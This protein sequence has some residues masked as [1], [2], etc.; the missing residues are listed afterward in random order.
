MNST[1]HH[2]KTFMQAECLNNIETALFSGV[3]WKRWECGHYALIRFPKFRKPLQGFPTEARKYV[4]GKLS[5]TIFYDDVD[6]YD[7]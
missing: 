1:E 3:A 6:K 2:N 5:Y 4:R 7:Y